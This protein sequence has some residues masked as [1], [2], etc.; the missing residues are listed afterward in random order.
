MNFLVAFILA[1]LISLGF[2]RS[3]RGESSGMPVIFMFILLV[4]AGLAAQY[5]VMP[6]G[7]I[8]WGIAWMP[9]VATVLIFTVLL[10][11]PS[12][13]QG[14]KPREK[15]EVIQNEVKAAAT[16]SVFMWLL[17]FLLSVAVLVGYFR[18]PIM[19]PL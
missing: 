3:Y 11:M 7:P 8:V 5:W 15:K 13:Y 1:L 9:L 16:I 4:L 12:P 17:L 6:F 19:N 10:I 18:N 2:S 14:R